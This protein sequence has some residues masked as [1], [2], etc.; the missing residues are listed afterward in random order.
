M[1]QPSLCGTAEDHLPAPPR[2]P[3]TPPVAAMASMSMSGSLNEEG[4]RTGISIVELQKLQKLSKETTEKLHRV[5]DEM[6]LS[7]EERSLQLNSLLE[8]VETVFTQ[9][10]GDEVALRDEYISAA[11]SL[12]K[13]I[14][15]I[16]EQLGMPRKHFPH[17]DSGNLMVKLT[18]LRSHLADFQ[19]IKEE[20]MTKLEDMCTRLQEIRIQMG[21]IED[22]QL[23]D[24]DAFLTQEAMQD[25]ESKLI[26][27]THH[28]TRRI[29]AIQ[30]TIRD[31]TALFEELEYDIQDDIDKAI[32]EGGEGLGIDMDAVAILSQRAREL[33]DEKISRTERL[34]QLGS[35]I[36]PLWER[37]DVDTD[38][39]Q[40]FFMDNRG[41][42]VGVIRQ[43]ELELERLIHLKQEMMGDLIRNAQAKIQELW[44]EMKFDDEQREAF[45]HAHM[46]AP[47]C[48]DTLIAHE[49]EIAVLNIQAELYRPI[50]KAVERYEQLCEE[51][52]D[53]EAKIQDSSRL[54]S[55]K[56]GSAL[57]EEEAQ[58][59]RVTQGLPR[60]IEKIKNTIA[61]YEEEHGPF[62]LNGR[63]FVE[64]M[65][66]MEIEH[67]RQ[68]AEAKERK[69]KS[70]DTKEDFFPGSASRIPGRT[71][72]KKSAAGTPGGPGSSQ[73][74]RPPL[75]SRNY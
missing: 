1:E 20:R 30:E 9:K 69:K 17:G 41:L 37:L 59:R 27:A 64:T 34:K 63:R 22:N 42:G 56:G 61:E 19:A 71:P 14:D 48:E 21:E 67:A 29:A 55:R 16:S 62:V 51:R 47:I 65:D 24:L 44:D 43:C 25:Y 50:L 45:T 7:P 35:Q 13:E 70:K 26:E 72:S 33:T 23:M 36:Q 2:Q 57:R 18:W 60:T 40:K 12:E 74:T 73:R 6:G 32:M 31:I 46:M 5:W 52:D 39:R 66:E 75:G 49:E 58:R 10:V 68:L 3:A 54:L 28:K 11:A 53:Y 15:A 8:A 38:T 4:V